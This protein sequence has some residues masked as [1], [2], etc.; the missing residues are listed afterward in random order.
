M[1]KLKQKIQ[2]TLLISIYVSLLIFG[3]IQQAV[4]E[5]DAVQ[6]NF[7]HYIAGKD[8]YLKVNSVQ[9]VKIPADSVKPTYYPAFPFHSGLCCLSVQNRNGGFTNLVH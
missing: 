3:C 6:V 4:P 8:H 5:I 9:K 7:T 2:I 1:P